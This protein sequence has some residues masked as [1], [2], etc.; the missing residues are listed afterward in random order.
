MGPDPKFKSI[1]R[2]SRNNI[3]TL[4]RAITGHSFMKRH[5]NEVINEED[6]TSCRLC[7]EEDET[8][9]HVITECPV[10]LHR[11]YD[12]FGKRFLNE[13]FTSWKVQDMIHFLDATII[14]EL[15]QE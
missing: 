3:S 9:H 8:P 6:D 7:M 11:R 14:K 13:K 5:Q 1:I 4:I 15:E 12:Y 10:L 2:Y